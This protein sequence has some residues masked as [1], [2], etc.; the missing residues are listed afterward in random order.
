MDNLIAE[1]IAVALER[2]ADATEHTAWGYAGKA[3]KDP[4]TVTA[5][6]THALTEQFKQRSGPQV[7]PG[8]VN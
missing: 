4:M 6:D 8:S 3:K 5:D 1:R 7:P 2:I